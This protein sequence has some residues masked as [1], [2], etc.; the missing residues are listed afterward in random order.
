MA[1]HFSNQFNTQRLIHSHRCRVKKRTSEKESWNRSAN[2]AEIISRERAGAWA[3][4]WLSHYH[5]IQVLGQSIGNKQ[6]NQWS[7]RRVIKARVLRE[8]KRS[9]APGSIVFGKIVSLSDQ[10]AGKIFHV[11]S[12]LWQICDQTWKMQSIKVNIGVRNNVSN[13]FVDMIW[14]L[15]ALGSNMSCNADW[16]FLNA[17]LLTLPV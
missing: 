14:V 3:P 6:D 7:G 5:V 16:S 9:L 8:K 1:T 10:R 11:E 15:C 12:H 2:N 17:L 13:D 4:Q